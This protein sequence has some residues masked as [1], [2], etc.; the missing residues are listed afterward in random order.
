MIAKFS[1]NIENCGRIQ[2]CESANN[3]LSTFCGKMGQ[4][5]QSVVKVVRMANK[6]RVCN[7]IDDL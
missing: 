5:C 3:S 1:K 6:H 7:V 2:F 4:G